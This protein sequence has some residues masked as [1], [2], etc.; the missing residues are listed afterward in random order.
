MQFPSQMGFIPAAC[1]RF[2]RAKRAQAF[3]TQAEPGQ[4]CRLSVNSA[5]SFWK[6]QN[7]HTM[8]RTVLSRRQ[9]DAI[10]R[11]VNGGNHGSDRRWAAYQRALV[12]FRHSPP[13]R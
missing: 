5:A 10:S 13:Q 1:N 9:F 3:A 11:I 6:S 7:L 12:A 4:L 2:H 8:T